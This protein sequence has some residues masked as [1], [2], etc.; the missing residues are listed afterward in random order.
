M[1]PL[2][3]ARA[4]NDPRELHKLAVWYREFAEQAGNPAIWEARLKTAEALEREASRLDERA[5]T[6]AKRV[7]LSSLAERAAG[8]AINDRAASR[9]EFASTARPTSSLRTP[10]GP[11]RSLSELWS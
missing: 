7:A 1:L 8:G 11:S 9:S 3:E 6:E 10:Q 5:R 4:M 2:L